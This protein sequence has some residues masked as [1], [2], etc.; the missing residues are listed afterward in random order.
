MGIFKKSFDS[1][2][3]KLAKSIIDYAYEYV[4]FDEQ[5]VDEV[6]VCCSF[7]E[8]S[9]GVDFFYKINGQLRQRHKVNFGNHHY[10]ISDEYQIEV[11]RAIRKEFTAIIQ[12][13]QHYDRDIP[14]QLK[15]NYQP[16]TNAFNSK[17]DYN[18][19]WSNTEDLLPQDISDRWFEELKNG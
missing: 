16:K 8:N 3:Q 10:K 17:L 18:L 12:L 11:L 15:M 5:H 14:T 1:Q 6:L 7:E 9:Y 19:H 2:Y 13:F 4:E